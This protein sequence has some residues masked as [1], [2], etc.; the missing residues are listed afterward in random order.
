MRKKFVS[1]PD[2]RPTNLGGR[3]A[4]FH[5]GNEDTRGVTTRML[6]LGLRSSA[7]F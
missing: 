2:N 7:L 6:D 4:I 3:D 1:S 5:E